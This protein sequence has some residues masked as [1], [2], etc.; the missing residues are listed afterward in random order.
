MNETHKCF[1]CGRKIPET[2]WFCS[3]KCA[4]AERQRQERFQER[5]ERQNGTRGVLRV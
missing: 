4:E 3:N 1:G 5:R 2:Q